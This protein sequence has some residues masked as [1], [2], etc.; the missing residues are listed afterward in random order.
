MA[1][2]FLFIG[3]LVMLAM[4]MA[5]TISMMLKHTSEVDGPDIKQNQLMCSPIQTGLAAPSLQLGQT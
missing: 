4:P 3:T 1:K 5:I 2:E